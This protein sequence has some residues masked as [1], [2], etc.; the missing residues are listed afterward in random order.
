L[1]ISGAPLAKQPSVKISIFRQGDRAKDLS[2]KTSP[3]P[4][5]SLH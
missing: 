4:G 1:V 5:G 3:S 2:L